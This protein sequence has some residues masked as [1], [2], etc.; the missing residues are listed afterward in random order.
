[1]ICLKLEVFDPVVEE[2]KYEVLT[3]INK[4]KHVGWQIPK[5]QRN[6]TTP[7]AAEALSLTLK[8]EVFT[9]Q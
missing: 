3:E 1:M 8:M 7:S 5:F 6:M 4:C 9:W 2:S